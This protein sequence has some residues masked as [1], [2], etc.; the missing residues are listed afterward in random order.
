M[1]YFLIIVQ[2]NFIGDCV[3]LIIHCENLKSVKLADL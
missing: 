1:H 3:D 2:E